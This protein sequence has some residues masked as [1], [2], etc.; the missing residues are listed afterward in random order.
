MSDISQWKADY[1]RQLE[2]E[3][4]EELAK[5]SDLIQ[6]FIKECK[7]RDIFLKENDFRFIYTIGIVA[8]YSN[9]VGLLCPDLQ[10][11]KEGLLDFNLLSKRFDRRPMMNG[12]LYDDKFMLM[13]TP[14][15][16]RS[17]DG[18]NNFAPRFIEL[19]WANSFENIDPFIS[20]DYDRV[21]IN[22]DNMPYC[23][24]D[25]WFGANFNRGINKI[26]DGI[27]KLKPPSDLDETMVSLFFSDAY[28]LD[29]KWETKGSIKSF[30]SEEFK[31][32]K[33]KVRKG[34][35]EF[36]P[37][38][39]VHAEY[40][41]EKH[42]FR[43]FDGAIHFYKENEYLQRRDS[44]FNYNQKEKQQIK[45]LSEKLFKMNGNISVD[46]WITFTSHFMTG[47][48]LVYEYFEGRFPPRILE[49]LDRFRN[50]T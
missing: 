20:I 19:F 32:D 23:E 38:R 3:E 39:Y 18:Y 48:P 7:Q 11:D 26:G 37:V 4:R 9:I 31:T 25:T 50:S 13:A 36:F 12:Y 10:K 30:Q 2:E 14:Y 29:I 46:M 15:F 24:S 45:T 1:F 41:L 28:S 8:C 47:N 44:D 22:I 21:R 6:S 17:Y 40:D 42:A 35:Q 43:H 34:R 5:N 27:V 16:R 33:I 49:I